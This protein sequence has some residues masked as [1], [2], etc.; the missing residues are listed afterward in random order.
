MKL[1]ESG[2]IYF[3]YNSYIKSIYDSKSI[4]KIFRKNKGKWDHYTEEGYKIL[5]KLISEKISL[6]E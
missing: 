1:K 3:D 6:I 5:S 2:I 4:D